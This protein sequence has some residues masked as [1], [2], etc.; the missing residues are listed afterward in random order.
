MLN[1]VGMV[2]QNTLRTIAAFGQP[3]FVDNDVGAGDEIA[4][5]H[6]F[7]EVLPELSR[8]KGVSH[9][10][11]FEV[12]LVCHHARKVYHSLIHVATIECLVA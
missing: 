4:L 9:F 12:V 6:E 3:I 11:C 10:R 2:V 8:L 7:F 1:R 5:G